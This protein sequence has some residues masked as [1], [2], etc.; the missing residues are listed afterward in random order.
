[1]EK[2]RKAK[3]VWQGGLQDGKGWVSTESGTLSDIPYDFA[4]RFGEAAGTN[5]EELVAAAHAACFAM[6]S[7]AELGKVGIT[8]EKIEAGCTIKF[9]MVGDAPTV[10]QAKLSATVVI[11]AGADQEKARQAVEAAKAG[12]PISRLLNAPVELELEIVQ[13]GAAG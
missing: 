9:E 6:A 5:P 7:S 10:T 1:M 4:K 11:P 2:L 12:C 8:S 3:A 13:S